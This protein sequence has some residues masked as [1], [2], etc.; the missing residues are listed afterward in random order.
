MYWDLP[1]N[2]F[3]FRPVQRQAGCIASTITGRATPIRPIGKGQSR[4]RK[5]NNGKNYSPGFPIELH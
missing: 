2:I 4:V 3:R 1:D 5:E